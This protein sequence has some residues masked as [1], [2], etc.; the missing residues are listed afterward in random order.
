MGELKKLPNDETLEKA[1]MAAPLSQ[2]MLDVAATR[3]AKEI[4][5]AMI[6]AK[7]F[8]RDINTAFSRIIRACNRTALAEQAM[9]SYPRGNTTVSG[10]SIRLAEAMA[11]NWGNLDFGIVEL[12]Q[13]EGESVM[14]AYAWDLETNTRQTKIFNVPHE[15]HTKRGVTP[16]V[17]PRDIYEA[18]ANQGARRLRACILGIIPGDIQEAAVKQC[19]KTLAGDTSEPLADRVRKLIA[20]FDQFNVGKEMIE[21]RL[22]HVVDTVTEHELVALRKIFQSLRDNMASVESFFEVPS[23]DPVDL[24]EGKHEAPTKK[25]KTTQRKASAAKDKQQGLLEQ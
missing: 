13:H 5:A 1:E 20:A 22:G 3:A 8:P 24:G 7:R 12:E 16:L 25:P 11:Q 23:D 6:M 15:R 10:P 18:T 19:E 17:D 9:Y 21:K 14:M 4:Q 2:S